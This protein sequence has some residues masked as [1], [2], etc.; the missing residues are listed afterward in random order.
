MRGL[1]RTLK[2]VDAV[3]LAAGKAAAF[4]AVP[5]VAALV[6]EVLARY[7]FGRPTIWSYETTYMI[8]GSHYLLGAAFTLYYKGHI[9]IDVIYHL[10]PQRARAA[11]DV[12]GYLIVFFPVTFL[13]SYSGFHYAWESF[14][15][16]EVSQ[17]TPWAPYLWPY[18]TVIFLGFALL[19]IQGLAEFTRSV[20]TLVRGVP[21]D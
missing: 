12:L 5:M 4:L 7:V 10:F 21:H 19:L 6:Y 9:R 1:T 14:S 20:A 3:S 11:V 16:K 17:Y 13:L 8:Y 2:G 18:K 15:T